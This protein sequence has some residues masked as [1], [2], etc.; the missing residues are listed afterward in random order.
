MGKGWVWLFV[1]ALAALLGCPGG[2]RAIPPDT[3]PPRIEN[4]QVN[5]TTLPYRGGDVRVS[6]K[7]SDPSG[8]K[9]V[10]AEV[11]KPDGTKER[12]TMGLVG[13]VYQGTITAGT[14]TRSDGVEEIY[15]VWVKGKD[16]KGN[17]TPE[18]G[19]PASGVSFKVQA[20]LKPPTN[21]WQ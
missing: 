19:E 6:A 17:E 18:P 16:M 5:P 2:R 3:T 21:P 15:R 4:V 9:E 20:P 11:Q 10:W 12:V 7:V 14:N 13:G 1:F 8:V